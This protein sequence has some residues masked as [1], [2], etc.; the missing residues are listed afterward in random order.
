MNLLPLVCMIVGVLL[1][2]GMLTDG[3]RS[4]LVMFFGLMA[5]GILPAMSLLLGAP[6]P[7]RYT[8]ARVQEMDDKLGK[9]L[10]KLMSTLKLL[11]A[12]G[13]LVLVSQFGIGQVEFLTGIELLDAVIADAPDRLLQAAVF[14][15]LIIALDRLRVVG[16][17]FQVV[18]QV[19]RDMALDDALKRLD[20][21]AMSEDDVRKAFPTTP[22]HGAKVALLRGNGGGKDAP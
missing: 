6:F 18:R 13:A 1:P 10:D 3:M 14:T 4:L 7:S 20:T 11:I 9:L 19:R 22:G 15:C 17:A 8:V 2:P 12:G 16:F 5:T 21:S